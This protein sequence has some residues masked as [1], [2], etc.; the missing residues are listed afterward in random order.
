[1]NSLGKPTALVRKQRD[2]LYAGLTEV[3]EFAHTTQCAP[4][5][6]IIKSTLERVLEVDREP[7]SRE[8]FYA[9]QADVRHASG[10]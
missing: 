5:M 9:D 6:R 4:V 7:Q 8:D 1:M 3:L 10:E 2:V